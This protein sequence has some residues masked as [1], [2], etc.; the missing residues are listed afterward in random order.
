MYYLCSENKSTDQLHGY[1]AADLGICFHICKKQVFSCSGL[2]NV[3]QV[4]FNEAVSRAVGAKERV[5]EELKNRE[6]EMEEEIR[7]NKG[8]DSWADT[9]IF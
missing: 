2:F 1:R 9:V 5:I 8:T 3:F 4:K 6:R 7:T